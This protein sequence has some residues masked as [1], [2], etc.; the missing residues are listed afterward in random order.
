MRCAM[1]RCGVP[2]IVDSD[3]L[4]IF[5][6]DS[7]LEV[8]DT[9]LASTSDDVLVAKMKSTALYQ[10]LQSASENKATSDVILGPSDCLLPMTM[11][12]LQARFQTE[13]KDFVE[14][15]YQD[16]EGEVERAQQVVTVGI[17]RGWFDDINRLLKE[18]QQE[19]QGINDETMDET[20]NQFIT[21]Y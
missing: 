3:D 5:I 20:D 7:W 10:V 11:E 6:V 2:V 13:T 15:M 19:V 1:K 16:Y 12:A 4:C 9:T 21:T 14:G 17:E 8:T 18:A